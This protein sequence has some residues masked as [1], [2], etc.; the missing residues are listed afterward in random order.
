MHK[1]EGGGRTEEGAWNWIIIRSTMIK[2]SA[3]TRSTMIKARICVASH[4]RREE[5][6]GRREPIAAQGQAQ[7]SATPGRFEHWTREAQVRFLSLSTSK[8][9]TTADGCHANGQAV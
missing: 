4:K 5:G 9:I 3:Q 1:K 2:A 6:G 7:C 8:P